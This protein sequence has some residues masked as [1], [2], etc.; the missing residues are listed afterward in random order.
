MR[1]VEQVTDSLRAGDIPKAYA[2]SKEYE[3]SK[4][5]DP[6]RTSPLA[7]N[8]PANQEI[9]SIERLLGAKPKLLSGLSDEDLIK[10]RIST[11]VWQLG[12][13][14][15][16]ID[17]PLK[18]FAGLP[19]LKNQRLRLLMLN[20][21]NY[22][23]GLETMRRVGAKKFKLVS[24]GVCCDNCQ[25]YADKELEI[26]KAPEAPNPD[27]LEIKTGVTCHGLIYKPVLNFGDE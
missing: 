24:S 23:N 3:Q 5:V 22:L 20:H 12:F 15:G 13:I 21:C 1:F 9:K 25:S 10:L 27:C 2:L 17:Y 14:K 18:D 4:P 7:I 11:A 26:D 8:I 6:K 19:P 16:D